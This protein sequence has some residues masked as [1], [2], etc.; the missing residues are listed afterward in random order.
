MSDNWRSESIAFSAGTDVGM[1]RS[2][3]QDHYCV[4]PASSLRLWN[5]RG[6]LFIV[7]DG[8]GAHAAGERASELATK[9]VSQSY[10]K[11]TNENPP[12]ALKNAIL[13]AHAVIKKQGEVDRAFE[14]MGTTCDALV[15][16]P[17]RGYIGH[18]GDS[19]VYRVR[20]GVVEQMTRDHSL[21]WEVRHDPYAH[22][23]LRRVAH[24]PKNVITRSLGPT[25]NLNVDLEGPFVLKPGDVF[26]LCSDGL[27][28]QVSD[29]EIGQILEIFQ[30]SDATESLVNLANL[31]GGPD[32]VTVVVARI[33]SVSKTEKIDQEIKKVAKIYEKRPPL[34]AVALASSIAA[35]V[36]WALAGVLM[37]V[38]SSDAPG[39]MGVKIASAAL[40]AI[41]TTLFFILGRASIFRAPRLDQD[42][43]QLVKEPYARASAAPTKEFHENIFAVCDELCRVMKNDEINAKIKLEPDCWKKIDEA[44]RQAKNAADRGDYASSIRANFSVVNYAMGEYKK[45]APPRRKG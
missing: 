25:E 12:E 6:H 41:C 16:L 17:D 8:M 4:E 18:V 14:N 27:S 38:D 32:N 15:L 30:P 28:G 45:N 36:F 11:R 19:R 26:L 37:L 21:V 22:P 44:R 29:A 3:N 13:E 24:I 2:N 42:D 10:L 35:F 9:I 31:R 7:A 40:A 43:R 39:L 23:D 1:R 20:G 33:K 34:S 5:A